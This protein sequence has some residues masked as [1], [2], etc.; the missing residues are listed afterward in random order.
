MKNAPLKNGMMITHKMLQK[1]GP[2]RL[3]RLKRD[4]RAKRE[5]ERGLNQKR[6]LQEGRAY[7]HSAETR[8]RL[9]IK[10]ISTGGLE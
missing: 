2:S 1:R 7:E 6:T 3:V 8:T 5:K 9:G 10:T 4:R